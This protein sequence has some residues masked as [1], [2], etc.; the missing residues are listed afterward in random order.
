MQRFRLPFAG[1]VM[2]GIGGF[3]LFATPQN[4]PLWFVWLGGAF[5]WYAGL[6][7]TLGG[8]AAALFFPAAPKLVTRTADDVRVLRFHNFARQHP[9]PSGILREIPAMGG[10][11][12]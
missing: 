3:L 9:A 5:L 12:L 1:L 6:A 4:L 10:F 11:I 8:L 2:V 7:V